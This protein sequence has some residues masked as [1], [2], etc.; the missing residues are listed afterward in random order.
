VIAEAR[1]RD[2]LAIRDRDD[3]LAG[4]A[5]Q[6]RPSISMVILSDI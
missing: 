3:H 6:V 5:S 4:A 2:A 1:D